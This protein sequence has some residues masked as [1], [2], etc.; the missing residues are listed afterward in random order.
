MMH[1]KTSPQYLPKHLL[2]ITTRPQHPKT[3]QLPPHTK[4]LI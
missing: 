3:F 2:W 1:Q 4:A